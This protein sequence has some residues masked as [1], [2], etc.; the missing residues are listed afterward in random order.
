ME[1]QQLM[2]FL[3]TCMLLSLIIT[4]D[5]LINRIVCINEERA[6]EDI[7]SF[8]HKKY[9]ERN[10]EILLLLGVCFFLFLNWVRAMVQ[11]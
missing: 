8:L 10:Q 7:I 6:S 11:T 5:F 4:F 9:Q 1:P 2:S 3:G